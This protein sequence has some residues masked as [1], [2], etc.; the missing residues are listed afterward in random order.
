[1]GTEFHFC[2]VKRVLEVNGGDGC[3]TLQMHLMPL[4]CDT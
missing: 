3:M 4:N 1:M 2:K